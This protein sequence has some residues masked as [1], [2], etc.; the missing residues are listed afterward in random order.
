LGFRANSL[1]KKLDK[2]ICMTFSIDF[3]KERVY[4]GINRMLK[5]VYTWGQWPFC[6]KVM[7]FWYMSVNKV[8]LG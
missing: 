5:D 8:G 2:N 7:W 6:G 3:D 1:F 4:W